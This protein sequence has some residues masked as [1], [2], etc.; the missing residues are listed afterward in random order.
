MKIKKAS[1][2]NFKKTYEK[3]GL[4]KNK[5]LNFDFD[6]YLEIQYKI[7]CFSPKNYFLSLKELGKNFK[8][9]IEKNEIS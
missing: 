3:I 9:E 8:K 2:K 7:Y 1:F 4:F 6:K 5:N